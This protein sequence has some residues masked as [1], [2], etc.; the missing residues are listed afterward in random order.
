[1]PKPD[2]ADVR[3]FKTLYGPYRLACQ[4]CDRDDFDGV[5]SLPKDWDDIGQVQTLKQSLTTYDLPDDP[6]PPKGYGVL[7]WYTHMGTC[8]DCLAR[9]KIE[10]AEWR[11]RRKKHAKNL[12]TK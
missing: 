10:S 8:P 6:K 3:D 11:K 5:K 2:S 9:Q 12:A 7:D 4:F 1:M